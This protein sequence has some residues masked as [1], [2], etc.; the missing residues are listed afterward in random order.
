MFEDHDIKTQGFIF[1]AVVVVIVAFGEFL[2][3]VL[4]LAPQ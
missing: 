3:Y 1:L 4:S 2:A